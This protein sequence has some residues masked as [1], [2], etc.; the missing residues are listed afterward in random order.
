MLS[1]PNVK[2]FYALV[3]LFLVFSCGDEEPVATYVTEVTVVQQ[4]CTVITYTNIDGSSITA[5]ECP[6]G[7]S[8]TI[9][10]AAVGPAGTDG[11]DGATGERGTD[12]SDGK[13][14]LIR[15]TRLDS[16]L[17]ACLADSGVLIETGIDAD[18]DGILSDDEVNSPATTA[19]C[20]GVDGVDGEDGTDGKDGNTVIIKPNSGGGKPGAITRP[21]K[22][23]KERKG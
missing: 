3:I 2:Y 21:V 16:G 15:L 14:S 6:D 22:R 4:G 11:N 8:T 7:T 23:S 17:A 12:G 20:D 5:L 19:L 13:T 9:P 18:G 10:A 1:S